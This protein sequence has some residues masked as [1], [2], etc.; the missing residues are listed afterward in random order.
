MVL[1]KRLKIR[2]RCQQG[3]ALGICTD[4]V[5]AWRAAGLLHAHLTNDKNEYLY[6]NPG[7]I[8]HG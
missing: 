5:K 4:Q 7:P 8:H 2:L 3:P 1:F 6:E